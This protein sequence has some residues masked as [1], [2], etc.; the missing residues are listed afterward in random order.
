MMAPGPARRD[1]A[2]GH[3]P[4]RALHPER[5]I[6]MDDPDDDRGDRREAVDQ[7]RRRAAESIV[8]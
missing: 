3:G 2:L 1:I 6:D 7:E 5:G 4:D 8:V